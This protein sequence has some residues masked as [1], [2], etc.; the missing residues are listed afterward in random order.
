MTPAERCTGNRGGAHVSLREEL[1]SDFVD[2]CVSLPDTESGRS[3]YLWTDWMDGLQGWG[4]GQ[5]GGRG[6][7]CLGQKL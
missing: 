4:E 6:N 7:F 2:C 5:V 3:I 1:M